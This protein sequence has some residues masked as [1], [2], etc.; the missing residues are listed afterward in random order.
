MFM[1]ILNFIGHTVCDSTDEQREVFFIN[2]RTCGSLAVEHVE[3]RDLLLFPGPVSAGGTFILQR[4]LAAVQRQVLHPI[5]GRATDRAA[6]Q[7]LLRVTLPA[8]D[9]DAYNPGL[10]CKDPQAR[11]TDQVQ[12]LLGAKFLLDQSLQAM[13]GGHCGILLQHLPKSGQDLLVP[14]DV[15]LHEAGNHPVRL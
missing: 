15:I 2:G 4:D 12:L 8:V 14:R 7:E 13:L 1:P 11:L 10:Q 5:Q 9:L 6:M 3:G